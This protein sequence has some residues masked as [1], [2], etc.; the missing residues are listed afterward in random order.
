[1]R[2][3]WN[4]SAGTGD[5]NP[6]MGAETPSQNTRSPKNKIFVQ[7]VWNSIREPAASAINS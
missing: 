4:G 7:D 3:P 2:I 1:M 5:A 6:I